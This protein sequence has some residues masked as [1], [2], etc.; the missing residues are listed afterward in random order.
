MRADGSEFVIGDRVVTM[1]DPTPRFPWSGNG[2]LTR[3]FR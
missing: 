3:I 1:V 2:W